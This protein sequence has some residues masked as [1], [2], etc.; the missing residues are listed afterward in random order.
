MAGLPSDDQTNATLV[1]E[2]DGLRGAS[3][4]AVRRYVPKAGYYPFRVVYFQGWGQASCELDA[5]EVYPNTQPLAL[6]NDTT[7]SWYLPAYRASSTSY[8]AAVTFTDPWSAAPT[9][10][11]SR[12]PRRSPTAATVRLRA[13]RRPCW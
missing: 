5:A 10:P 6:V 11:T 3:D 9:S 1:A 4:T 7:A 12:L 8:P 13:V 2:Y